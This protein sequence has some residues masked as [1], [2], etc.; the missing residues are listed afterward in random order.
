MYHK[1]KK[2]CKGEKTRKS[3]SKHHK[4]PSSRAKE[5]TVDVNH[6]N[7]IVLVESNKHRAFHL[8]FS[9]KLPHEIAQILND[10]WIQTDVKFVVVKQ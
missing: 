8:L 9:N 4:C 7:N 3:Y 6:P 5:A 1:F 2:F 10:T